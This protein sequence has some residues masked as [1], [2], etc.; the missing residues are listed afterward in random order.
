MEPNLKNIFYNK[1][2]FFK[3]ILKLYLCQKKT[4]KLENLSEKLEINEIFNDNRINE[5]YL[6]DQNLIKKSN[7][8]DLKGGVNE[9]DRKALYF[10]INKMQPNNILEVG[11]HIGSS[12]LSGACCKKIWW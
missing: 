10:L 7:I 12:T 8:P 6:E 2:N 9:G 5:N 1:F 11:T 3:S 4:F